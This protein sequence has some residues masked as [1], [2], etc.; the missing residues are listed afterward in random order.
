M[1]TIQSVR[2]FWLQVFAILMLP[3]SLAIGQE[4]NIG[5]RPIPLT[6]PE[7]KW[8]IEDVKVRIPRIPL[9][10]LNDQDR[11]KLGDQVDNYES[12]LRYHYLNGIEPYR[13]VGNPLGV[14]PLV[15]TRNG[16]SVFSS[17]EQDPLFSLDNAFKIELFWIVSRVN[18]CQYCIGHQESKLLS[19][20]RSEDQIAA[21]DGDWSEFS[22]A[23][24]LAFAFARKFT[25]Q[26]YLFS[27][28]DIVGLQAHFTNAQ[29]LEMILSMSGNNSINRW[30]EG[31]GVPQRIDEGGYSRSATLGQ[32]GQTTSEPDPKLPRG[33]YLTPTSNAFAK[34]ISNVAVISLDEKTGMPTSVTSSTRQLLES[35][36]HVEKMIANCR[37]RSSRLPLVDD[38]QARTNIPAC[39]SLDGAMPKWIRLIANFPKAGSIRFE[40]IRAAEEKGDLSPLFKAQ[41]NWILARQ[42]RAWYALGLAQSRLRELGQSDVQIFALDGD[43]ADYSARDKSLIQVAKHL[44]VSPVILSDQ[45]VSNAIQLAGPR[46][47]VQVISYTGSR[48]S[49]NRL[50]EAAGLPL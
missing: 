26:P 8:F 44:A 13:N 20:G 39:A 15:G 27:D 31:V 47:V 23:S 37:T 3:L 48:A 49:F 12:R 5:V 45:E 41:L 46:D 1:K 24:K 33:T 11:E 21:L 10:N 19:A 25:Y 50:T 6:R 2:D 36:E 28:N 43:L 17:R 7:L 22:P 34:K 30:K 29:I 16:Q 42:D 35:R 38:E 18:N 9:P 14:P 40:S 32:S 4:T